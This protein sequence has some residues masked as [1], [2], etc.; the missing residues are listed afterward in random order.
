MLAVFQKVINDLIE[1]NSS[2]LNPVKVVRVYDTVELEYRKQSRKLSEN[3]YK[4]RDY[5][6]LNFTRSGLAYYKGNK[7]FIDS[8]NTLYMNGNKIKKCLSRKI[9][10]LEADIYIVS[11]PYDF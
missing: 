8:E 6:R 7:F 2:L 4:I 3:R 9:A 1:H 11:R 5:Q 10:R